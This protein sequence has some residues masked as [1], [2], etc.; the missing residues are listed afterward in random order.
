MSDLL[1][2]AR[3]QLSTAGPHATRRACW[4]AR[5]ALEDVIAELLVDRTIQAAGASERAKLT[6]LEGAYSD[7]RGL[8]GQAQY[9]WHRLSEACHQ[10][11]FELSPTHGEARDL[12]DIVSGIYG[13]RKAQQEEKN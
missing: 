2:R 1:E 10:H 8:A 6:M 5:A 12:I 13:R 9:A 3:L 7:S 4:L 11:A